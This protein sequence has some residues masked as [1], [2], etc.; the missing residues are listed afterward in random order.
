MADSAAAY[1][2]GGLL[3]LV[4][5]VLFAVS[6]RTSRRTR[7]YCQGFN[8]ADAVALEANR[9]AALAR[10]Y[11]REKEYPMEKV[12]LIKEVELPRG[13]KFKQND[14]RAALKRS[15]RSLSKELQIAKDRRLRKRFEQKDWK[16]EDLELDDW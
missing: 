2:C 14:Q 7:R 6:M 3:F 11:A 1:C 5:I 8:A 13:H 9:R 10:K 12:K 16:S 4:I 15:K